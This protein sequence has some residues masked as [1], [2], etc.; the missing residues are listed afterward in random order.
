MSYLGGAL[1][2]A[3]WVGVVI[4]RCVKDWRDGR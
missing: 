2:I 3:L 1:F 4:A